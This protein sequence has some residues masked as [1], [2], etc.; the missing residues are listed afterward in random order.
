MVECGQ[1]HFHVCGRR[2]HD[3]NQVNVFARYQLVPVAGHMLN[4]KLFGNASGVFWISAGNS[5]NARAHAIPK[6]GNL[7]SAGKAGTYD[8]DPYGLSVSH[9]PNFLLDSLK[10]K[11]HRS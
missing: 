7:C 8:P 6:S 9:K 3:A 10:W 5:D 2:R 1:R 4:F 11:D